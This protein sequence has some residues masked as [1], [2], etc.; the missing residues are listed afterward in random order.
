MN[1]DVIC[2]IYSLGFMYHVASL[3]IHIY[4]VV[5]RMVYLS[6]I[7]EAKFPQMLHKL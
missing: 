1:N 5:I 2:C 4:C 3:C 6:L 7:D